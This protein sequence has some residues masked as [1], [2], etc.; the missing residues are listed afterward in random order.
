M[1]LLSSSWR[2][3]F[4]SGDDVWARKEQRP[5][6]CRAGIHERDF[7]VETEKIRPESTN[8]DPHTF[9][10]TS[11]FFPGLCVKFGYLHEIRITEGFA[12]PQSCNMTCLGRVLHVQ[13]GRQ[14]NSMWFSCLPMCCAL[15]TTYWGVIEFY[16]LNS[17]RILLYSSLISWNPIFHLA[18]WCPFSK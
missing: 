5:N 9:F 2:I 7:L 17:A 8:M 4:F 1:E 11:S 6:G 16:L 13:G 14:K 10:F 3:F 12:E 18:F 15:E